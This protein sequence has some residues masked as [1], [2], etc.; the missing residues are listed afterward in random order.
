MEILRRSV[1]SDEDSVDFRTAAGF[2]PQEVFVDT[3]SKSGT[4]RMT[5]GFGHLARDDEL[6]L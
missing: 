5:R 6:A 1:A 2:A 3:D 4:Y